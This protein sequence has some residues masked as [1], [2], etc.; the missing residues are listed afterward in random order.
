MLYTARAFPFSN[1]PI[2]GVFTDFDLI[3]VTL[4]SHS[5]SGL[6]KVIFAVSPSC[7]L[8]LGRF[9]VF[10]GFIAIFSIMISSFILGSMCFPSNPKAVSNPIIPFAALSTLTFCF[11]H[12]VG[13]GLL[14][15]H[16]LY[17][18]LKH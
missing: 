13:Y 9:K 10:L 11:L 17:H 18:Q 3:S 5:K 1:S 2:N 4:N 12:L 7:I 8:S 15:L 14:R 6:N 16:L